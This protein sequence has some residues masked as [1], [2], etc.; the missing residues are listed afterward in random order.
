MIFVI[1]FLIYLIL[2]FIFC[3]LVQMVEDSY[4]LGYTWLPF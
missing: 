3:G 2:I 4:T 1:L